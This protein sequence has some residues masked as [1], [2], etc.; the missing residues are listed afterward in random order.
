[1]VRADNVRRLTAAGWESALGHGV[2]RLVDLRFDGEG[3]GEPSPPDD[4]EV[5]AVSLFGPPDPEAARRSST[6]ACAMPTT[7]PPSSPPRYINTLERSPELIAEA[8][9]AV[10]DSDPAQ[11]VVVHCF[12][13]K[14]RTGIISALLLGVAGVP[15]EVVAAD[16]AASGPGV[17]ALSAPWFAK[18]DS[19][20]VLELRRRVVQSPHAAMAAVLALAARRS[21]RSGGLPAG[22]GA[23][24]TRS[25]NGYA[26]G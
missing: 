25:S 15:D 14:D 11:G 13:G 23:S 24:R 7:S 18:A 2:R 8:V 3:A 10:A 12:A 26:P 17:E 4:V 5:V 16:Y 22:C 21:R 1:M 9:T 19:D 6:I 20:E